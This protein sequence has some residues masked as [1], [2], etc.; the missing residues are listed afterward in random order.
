MGKTNNNLF[1]N[2]F[3]NQIEPW[4]LYRIISLS[5]IFTFFY[6]LILQQRLSKTYRILGAGT[7]YTAHLFSKLISSPASETPGLA[8]IDAGIKLPPRGQEDAK[9]YYVKGKM[10]GP[11]IC[12]EPKDKG[13]EPGFSGMLIQDVYKWAD[14]YLSYN[15]A[16]VAQR[17]NSPALTSVLIDRLAKYG[18]PLYFIKQNYIDPTDKKVNESTS[19]G[20]SAED[21]KR[22][23]TVRKSL[24]PSIMANAGAFFGKDTIYTKNL[25]AI[26][27]TLAT[28]IAEIVMQVQKQNL[29][30]G[31]YQNSDGQKKFT[32]CARWER[33][34]TDF[35]KQIIVANNNQGVLIKLTANDRPLMDPRGH[36]L[37]DDTITDLGRIFLLAVI[38][39]DYDF[40]GSKGGNKGRVGNNFFGIDFGHCLRE[41]NEIVSGLQ[42]DFSLPQLPNK[43]KNFSIFFDTEIAQKHECLLIF[44][45]LRT[46]Q[47][48]PISVLAEYPFAFQKKLC[49]IKKDDD[50]KI[51]DAFEKYF[52]D[53]TQQIKNARLYYLNA[54]NTALKIFE[55]RINLN[56]RT[57]EFID[58][59]EKLCS[60]TSTIFQGAD[61]KKVQLNHLYKASRIAFEPAPA[62]SGFFAVKAKEGRKAKEELIKYVTAQKIDTKKMTAKLQS[63]GE[64]IFDNDSFVLI[65]PNSQL[66]P[67]YEHFSERKIAAYKM[68]SLPE[69]TSIKNAAITFFHQ[70]TAAIPY[71]PIEKVL[72]AIPNSPML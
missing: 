4:F 66:E 60:E 27:E 14:K 32:T 8:F 50:L 23:S 30:P 45:K 65:I 57:L 72:A 61:N 39:N 71:E 46:G 67:F 52:P 12:Y 62:Q 10:L 53:Y 5:I 44:N 64:G 70:A 6:L 47:M 9:E 24:L 59:L 34:F 41:Q 16:A 11:F 22:T 63:D 13:V 15:Q 28:A 58:N 2:N 7:I 18:I 35:E 25:N 48:P 17:L 3:F 31:N 37:S 40:V 56:P 68:Q 21:W 51:F 69:K 20:A 1:G 49:A 54:V 42:T 43:Y 36:Y 38:L 29:L 26:L 19:V 33:R 55:N